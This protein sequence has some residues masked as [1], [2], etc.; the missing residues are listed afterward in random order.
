MN[1]AKIK[2]TPNLKQDTYINASRHTNIDD[3]KVSFSFSDFQT[4]S[5]QIDNFNKIQI[6]Y[7]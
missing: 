6:I 1:N 3:K 7:D 4:N 2:A 5:I